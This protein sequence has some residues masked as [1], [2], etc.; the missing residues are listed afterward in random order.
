MKRA[1][2]DK[3]PEKE[4][5]VDMKEMDRIARDVLAFRPSK[6]RKKKNPSSGSRAVRR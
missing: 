5:K 1:K 6:H 2:K 3:Q 4:H